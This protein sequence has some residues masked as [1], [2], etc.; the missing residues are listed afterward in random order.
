MHRLV[1]VTLLVLLVPSTLLGQRRRGGGR[2][3]G[4]PSSREWFASASAGLQFGDYVTDE[5]SNSIWDFDASFA[6][7]AT[8]EREIAPGLGVGLM[9]SYARQPLTY[10]TITPSTTACRVCAADATVSSYGAYLRYGGGPGFHQLFEGF[11]G[12]TRFGNFTDR[13]GQTLPP[14]SNTDISFGI[15]AGFGY[16]FGQDWEMFVMQDAINAIHERGSALQ[17]GDRVARTLM[18]RLGIRVGF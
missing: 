15:G 5:S 11:L 1:L 7:R 16:G 14:V 9:F 4:G 8:I 17:G 3:G 12:A 13:S 10:Q 18:T 2:G 6:T